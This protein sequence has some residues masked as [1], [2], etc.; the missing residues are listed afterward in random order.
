MRH[1]MHNKK[2]GRSM[3]HRS[4]LLS[5]LVCALIREER[6]RTTLPKAREARRLAEK[7]VTLGRKQSISPERGVAARRLAAARLRRSDVVKKLFEDI[8]PRMEGRP[9]GYTRI[10]KIGQR[11]G[12][13]S[14]MAYLEWVG[15]ENISGKEDSTDEL[16]ETARETVETA[17]P[18]EETTEKSE[19]TVA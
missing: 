10:T 13:G 3:S 5:S 8:V 12:D 16:P 7:L 17:Q 15:P 11:R 6:I 14:E 1:K 4:A 9:G 18:E 2:L 19:E